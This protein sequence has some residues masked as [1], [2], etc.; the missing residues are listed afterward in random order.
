MA[1]KVEGIGSSLHDQIKEMQAPDLESPVRLELVVTRLKYYAPD[2]SFF[3]IEGVPQGRLPDLPDGYEQEACRL[4]GGVSVKGNSPLFASNDMVGSTF[5][6][7]GHWVLDPTHGMQFESVFVQDV[8]PTTTSGLLRYLSRGN[9]KGIG[10]AL[11]NTM[12][13]KWGME[14]LSIL[15]NDPEKL[16]ELPG[17]SADKAAA[18]GR[19]WTERKSDFEYL[20][21]FG[22]YG[23]GEM[24]TRRIREHFSDDGLIMRV[25]KNPYMITQV[26]GV[27]FKT[28]DL[29]AKNLGFPPDDPLRTQA[30]LDQVLRDRIQNAGHT[31][32]PFSEWIELSAQY[33]AQPASALEGSAR[34]LIREGRVIKRSLPVCVQEANGS[35]HQ[36][37]MDCVSPISIARHEETIAA[38]LASNREAAE[39][40]SPEEAINRAHGLSRLRSPSLGLDI[41]QQAAAWMALC[42]SCAVMTG[43]PGTGKTTTIRA[44]ANFLSSQRIPFRLVAPTGR[45]AKRMQEAIGFQASTIHRAL[46]YSPQSGFARNE[47]SPLSEDYIVVDEASMVDAALG[48]A[49]VR[50]IKPSA[51]LL[52]VGDVDQ[53]PSVGPGDVLRNLID[54]QAVPVS[55]LQTVHRQAKGSAIALNAQ[56]VLAGHPPVMDGNPAVEDFAF[57]TAK[58]NETI[59][60]GIKSMVRL[61]LSQGFEPNDIQI[62]CPQKPGAVG[63]EALNE[64]L[65]PLLNPNA[66][67]PPPGSNRPWRVG[68]RLMQTKNNY[69]KMVFN[70]DMGIV[71]RMDDDGGILLEMEDGAMVEMSKKESY[72][73]L[74]GFAITVHKSQGG[75]RPV[76]IMPMAPAHTFMLDRNLVYTGITRGKKKVFVV[77]HPKTALL[78]ISKKSTNIRLTGLIH[79]IERANTKV[80]IEDDVAPSG[81]GF[82]PG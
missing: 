2:T 49:L 46:E 34:K 72:D 20:A 21:F 5:A 65:R 27:G 67:E 78:A 15:D 17:I 28:A 79:E 40:M 37:Q 50:A 11:A 82:T 71:R 59:I 69:D 4:T 75:E 33:L 81:V 32:I 26:E 39:D 68:D 1:F 66:P 10:P 31:T 73:L 42:S 76:I 57:I 35:A 41:S 74:V 47:M 25:R 70:G 62:L 14:V 9:L 77:G 80:Q 38:W 7:H 51:K 16:S 52:W 23:I 3:V 48:A 61:A 56:R 45:A 44:V 64:I 18:I 53:L 8:I 60:E 63:T 58:D 54:S 6:C 55:R 22:E 43:G 12:V 19:L 36:V 30:A 29:M 24:T 13:K